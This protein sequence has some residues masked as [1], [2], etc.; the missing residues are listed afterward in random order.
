MAIHPITRALQVAFS[1]RRHLPRPDHTRTE[2]SR[3]TVPSPQPDSKPDSRSDFKPGS[4]TLHRHRLR[5]RR[6]LCRRAVPIPRRTQPSPQPHPTRPNPVDYPVRC[7]RPA[8]LPHQPPPKLPG[9]TTPAA[10]QAPAATIPAPP[11]DEPTPKAILRKAPPFIANFPRSRGSRP[12]TSASTKI[13][14][15]QSSI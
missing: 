10:A 12:T 11:P 3:R 1:S 13:S 6:N 4:Q 14:A 15:S 7:R 8:S 5:P 2:P 9:A